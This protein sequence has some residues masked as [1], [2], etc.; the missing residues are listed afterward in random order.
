MRTGTVGPVSTPSFLTG[1]LLVP[2]PCHVLPSVPGLGFRPHI[3]C[4]R[5]QL[6]GGTDTLSVCSGRGPAP[7]GWRPGRTNQAEPGPICGFCARAGGFK[8]GVETGVCAPSAPAPRPPPHILQDALQGRLLG[9]EQLSAPQVR[10]LPVLT[11]GPK[12]P[13][14]TAGPAERLGDGSGGSPLGTRNRSPGGFS[15]ALWAL[16]GNSGF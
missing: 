13:R 12:G 6:G 11:G 10:G 7:R 5:G 9:L 1:L 8:A 3:E 4:E 15:R 16:Q 2:S 14:A